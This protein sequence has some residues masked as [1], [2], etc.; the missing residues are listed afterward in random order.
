MYV[1]DPK[2]NLA[3]AGA[4]D[5]KPTA[6]QADLKGARNYVTEALAAVAAGKTPEVTTTRASGCSVKYGS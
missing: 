5:D 3:Y 6:S 4:I 1:I 2:G